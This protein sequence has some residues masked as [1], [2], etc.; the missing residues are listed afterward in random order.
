MILSDKEIREYASKGM[1]TP[2]NEKNLSPASYDIT[3]NKEHKVFKEPIEF[4][5]EYII[6]PTKDDAQMFMVHSAKDYDG[7]IYLNSGEFMLINTKERIELPNNIAA[8][9]FGRSSL[10]RWG[11]Q[12]TNAG[13]IDPGFRG[14]L[15]LQL[16]N[17]SPYT[18]NLRNIDRIAQLI[19]FEAGETEK[20]YNG[21][22]QDQTE[23][24][25]SKLLRD[26]I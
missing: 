20:G 22:Y 7:N 25:S 9:V 5:M 16:Y 11:I 14:N 1:I 6:D 23:V 3:F 15:T 4:G 13:W 12:I 24:T 18:F 21:K 8:K 2:F 26:F 19:F 17:Q 10:G